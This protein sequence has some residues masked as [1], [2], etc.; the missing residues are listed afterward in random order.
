LLLNIGSNL[1][2]LNADT[3]ISGVTEFIKNKDNTWKTI[4][5]ENGIMNK[6]TNKSDSTPIPG[7]YLYKKI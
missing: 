1:Y 4:P 5:N 7:F 6:I 3:R 2:Y